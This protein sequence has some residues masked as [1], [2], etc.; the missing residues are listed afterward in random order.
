MR[1]ILIIFVL[2]IR[3]ITIFLLLFMNVYF[4][5]SSIHLFTSIL[6][7]FSLSV[8][9]CSRRN[10]SIHLNYTLV[11]MMKTDKYAGAHIFT[12]C[13]VSNTTVTGSSFCVRKHQICFVE[14]EKISVDSV[15][16]RNIWMRKY[17]KYYFRS[18]RS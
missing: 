11:T 15:M 3:I 10:G 12:A 17:L 1:W 16:E 13:N 14:L 6:F 9:C 2:H 4:H 8:C 7:S 18:I 5:Y